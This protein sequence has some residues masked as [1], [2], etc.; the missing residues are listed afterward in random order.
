MNARLKW[1]AEG[2]RIPSS[3]CSSGRFSEMDIPARIDTV[4]THRRS[5]DTRP[6]PKPFRAGIRRRIREHLM[7][8]TANTRSTIDSGAGIWT[9]FSTTTLLAGLT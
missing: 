9:R 3:R 4:T 8:G 5:P 7:P 1:L 6:S 2:S